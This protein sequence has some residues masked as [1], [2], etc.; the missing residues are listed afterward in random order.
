MNRTVR[1]K[2]MT[3]QLNASDVMKFPLTR[4]EIL[5]AAFLRIDSKVNTVNSATLT[6]Q[7]DGND[8]K[9]GLANRTTVGLGKYVTAHQGGPDGDPIPLSGNEASVDIIIAGGGNL[10]GY[11]EIWTEQGTK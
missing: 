8:V 5:T 4:D 7:V 2:D 1:H 10:N 9:T 11:I 3:A 6:V